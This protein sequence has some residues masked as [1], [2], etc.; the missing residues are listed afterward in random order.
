MPYS[1]ASRARTAREHFIAGRATDAVGLFLSREDGGEQL[2]AGLFM[3]PEQAS[4]GLDDLRHVAIMPR[5]DRLGGKPLELRRQGHAIHDASIG[6]SCPELKLALDRTTSRKAE[7]TGSS[8]VALYGDEVGH[9]GMHLRERAEAEPLAFCFD[10]LERGVALCPRRFGP[11]QESDAG[12]DNFGNVAIAP[13][14]DRLG[15]KALQLWRQVWSG[16]LRVDKLVV[17]N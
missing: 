11:L 3:A 8:G 13:R 2:G 6:E 1:S 17:V 14:G 12:G 15:G 10:F 9:L 4:P 7:S 16:R 5:G